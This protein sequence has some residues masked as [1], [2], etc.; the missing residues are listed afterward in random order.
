MPN[1][2]SRQAYI[3]RFDYKKIT[4]QSINIF[5][6][7]EIAEYIYR[8]VVENLYKNLLKQ[9]PTVLVAAGK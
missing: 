7:M 4:K 3:K 8:G 1:I 9:M 2:R 5:E 6:H